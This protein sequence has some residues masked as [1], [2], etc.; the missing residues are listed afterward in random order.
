MSYF[1]VARVGSWNPIDCPLPT[2]TTST[3]AEGDSILFRMIDEAHDA[4]RKMI[5]ERNAILREIAVKETIDWQRLNADIM[6]H[7]ETGHRKRGLA[8]LV[9]H[10]DRLS[11]DDDL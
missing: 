8:D 2:T 4:G 9:D 5:N 3:V 6:M 10:D 7:D 1:F 11:D